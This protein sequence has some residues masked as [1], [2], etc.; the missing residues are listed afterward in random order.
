[1]HLQLPQ[2]PVPSDLR[3][4][5]ATQDPPGRL[6]TVARP[7]LESLPV[8]LLPNRDTPS[9]DATCRQWLALAPQCRAGAVASL[10]KN[11][12]LLLGRPMRLVQWSG[13]SSQALSSP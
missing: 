4:L 5:T 7:S 10:S 8:D 9:P 11:L 12:S 13:L 1:M 3:S 2:C 6:A